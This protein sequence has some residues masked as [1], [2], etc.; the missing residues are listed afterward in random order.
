M[1]SL[2]GEKC[3]KIHTLIG[4]RLIYDDDSLFVVKNG[5]SFHCAELV[6]FFFEINVLYNHVDRYPIDLIFLTL[7]VFNE[8]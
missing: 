5:I 7:N 6:F 2:L 8:L 4:Y 3:I 1:N